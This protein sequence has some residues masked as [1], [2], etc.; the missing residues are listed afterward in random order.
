MS[1]IFSQT[2]DP[3][4]WH[5]VSLTETYQCKQCI[6]LEND[7]EWGDKRPCGP[8]CVAF[9]FVSWKKMPKRKTNQA[10]AQLVVVTQDRCSVVHLPL[11][12]CNGTGTWMRRHWSN[13]V[14]I[15]KAQQEIQGASAKRCWPDL[16]WMS[17]TWGSQESCSWVWKQ[18]CP[19]GLNR[20]AVFCRVIGFAYV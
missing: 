20:P 8:T 13:T 19:C 12:H 1:R 16:T 4:V 15:W 5:S 17:S 14:R 10:W 9:T 7:H 3:Q 2:V 6:S 11:L 18:L